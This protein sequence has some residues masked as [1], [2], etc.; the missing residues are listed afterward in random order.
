VRRLQMETLVE[1]RET[2]CR[3]EA[4]KRE[5]N[6]LDGWFFF[7]DRMG[8][9]CGQMRIFKEKSQIQQNAM[10]QRVQR[11]STNEAA[12]STRKPVAGNSKGWSG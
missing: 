1:Q 11:V 2:E 6:A 4:Q 7:R 8:L 10:A 3:K 5:Q 9:R 12:S